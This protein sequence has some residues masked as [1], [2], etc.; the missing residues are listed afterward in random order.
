M[1][2]STNYP[3]RKKSEKPTVSFGTDG[4]RGPVETVLTPSL[5]L[6]LG[7]ICGTV[8]NDDSPILIGMDSRTSGPMLSSALSAGLM[9]TG[10]DIWE[11]G[12]CPTPSIPSLIRELNLAGGLMISASHNPPM[13]N[14]IKIFG[15]NGVKLGLEDQKIIE[16]ALNNQNKNF[17]RCHNQSHG[18]IFKR[19]DLLQNYCKQVLN[20][21]EGK[22][23]DGIRIVLDLCWGSATSC[24][25][26]LFKSLG[27]DVTVINGEPNGNLINVNCGSTN[28]SQLREAVFQTEASMGF[29]FDGDADRMLAIDSKGRLIDGDHVLYLWGS[30]LKQQSKLPG[31][32]LVATVMSNLG[33]EQAWKAKGGI[34]ERTPVGDQH[35]Y[36]AMVSNDTAL[37]GE[38]SGHILCRDNGLSGDG[39]L[40]ALNISTICTSK[41]LSLE[42][43][44]N[45]SFTPFPQK[46]VNIHVPNKCMRTDWKSCQ[47]LNEA[48]LNATEKMGEDGRVLIR[49]SGT[50][51]LLRVMVEASHQ[52]DVESWTSQLAKLAD[53]HLNAA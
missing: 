2:K 3:L 4:I 52:D 36:E 15:P 32:K 50:E 35:V 25:L 9:A 37:G 42:N 14:G 6:E 24:G 17:S 40:A 27:A 11:L 12:L 43:W 8:F 19:P 49:A 1:G 22:R 7:V 13:D 38:Q 45:K 48:V 44:L 51:P 29:G 26:D 10:K 5:A 46:L 41:G 30:E 34:L 47:P 23:L 18:K 31:N 53:Q 16:E 20:S 21:L 28:L 33:F 39:L